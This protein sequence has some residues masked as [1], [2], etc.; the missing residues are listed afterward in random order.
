LYQSTIEIEAL[1]SDKWYYAIGK[2]RFG[3]FT[4]EHLKGLVSS[5][6]LKEKDLVWTKTMPNWM[7]AE[8]VPEMFETL[9]PPLPNVDLPP[10]KLSE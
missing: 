8:S 6:Q 9:P 2:E 1:M 3:P 4:F 5:G 10:I 7:A